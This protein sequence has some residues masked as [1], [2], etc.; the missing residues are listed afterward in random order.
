MNLET[1][2]IIAFY[3]LFIAVVVHITMFFV[4]APFGRHT[5]E[6]WG[7]TVDNKLAWTI[8]ESPSLF[9]MLYYLCFGSKSFQSY[10][11]ILFGVWIFHYFNRTFIY[12]LRIKPTPKRMPLA[13]VCS[14]IFFNIVNA[15]LNGYYLSELA[16]STD[17]DGEW[18]TSTSFIIGAIMFLV[19]LIINWKSD[20]ILINL[21]K[22]GETGYKIPKGF[23]FD[24]VASPNLFGEII[25]WSGFALMAWNLPALTFMVW[26]FANL[27][28]RAKNHHDWYKRHFP[29]FPKER[30]VVFPFMY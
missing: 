23:L 9:I 3:W 16:P 4:T 2:R 28:P 22:P 17:Y 29:D 7:K 26:T 14:A 30:K 10:V 5:T 24:Y 21:R 27:V 13:I 25:E 12:P 15:G 18:L 1:L 11:W 20:T 19:G 6:K 8:M